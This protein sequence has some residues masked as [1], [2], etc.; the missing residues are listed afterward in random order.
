[1]NLEELKEHLGFGEKLTLEFKEDASAKESI[2]ATA[3][4]FLNTK[5]GCILVGV[6]DSGK[7]VGVSNAKDQRA[8]LD[9]YLRDTLSPTSLVAVE[10]YCIDEGEM[11]LLLIDVPEGK[12]K[13]FSFKDD[14]YLRKSSKTVKADALAIRDMVLASANTAERWERRKS[15]YLSEADLEE[16]ELQKRM[17]F[18]QKQNPETLTA[19]DSTE[20][21]LG[22]L[23][24]LRYGQLTNAGDLLF[25]RMPSLRIPQARVRATCFE[26]E[27]S[28]HFRANQI[29]EG[30]LVSVF[31][32]CL[33]FVLKN[34][35]KRSRFK[36]NQPE[37][38]D[39]Y[40]YPV[41]AI[42]EGLVNAFVH[43]D[44]ADYAGGITINIYPDRLEI[45][46]SG[47]FPQGITSENISTGHFIKLRNP[48]IANV[49]YLLGLMER[50][51]RGGRM[52]VRECENFGLLQPTWS[53]S[54]NGV[55]LALRLAKPDSFEVNKH[56]VKILRKCL[57]E[58]SI[59]ELMEIIGRSDRTKFRHQVLKP[60]LELG[61][62]EMTV[63]DKPQSSKQRYRLS[64][65][66]YNA[67]EA[68][69]N[70]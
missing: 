43:R 23:S 46:N 21:K 9:Q 59:G 53:S 65:L 48:D 31:E 13:P 17:K 52:I 68:I 14:F 63:P 47:S 70:E 2:G 19:S 37:R 12:D 8:K 27:A 57:K 32:Q 41:D 44:Y 55:T 66:G 4:A 18:I 45:H 58:S 15:V 5:G 40:I 67:L 61:L 10:V 20:E 49:F 1:M 11:S 56:Q 42:R 51:G 29:I 54:I 30:P 7:I 62:V 35:R 60:L 33:Q 6:D 3:S 26:S 50:I 69:E 36:T 64:S 22:R 38:T 16:N 24:L 25:S 34:T 39:E 28:D